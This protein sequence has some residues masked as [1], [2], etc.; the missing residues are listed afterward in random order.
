[1]SS[2]LPFTS[3]LVWTLWV[4]GAG[5]LS[6]SA[7][8]WIEG[9]YFQHQ[10]RQILKQPP[11][12]LPAAPPARDPAP[13]PPPTAFPAAADPEGLWGLLQ[14]PR[15]DLEVAVLGDVDSRSLRLGAGWIPG[16]SSPEGTGNTGIAGH[17]DTVFRKLSGIQPGDAMVLVR[18]GTAYRYSVAWT[19]V[20][21]PEDVDVLDATPEPALTLV[22]CYPF[23]YI[24]PA[25]RRFI[26]RGKRVPEKE[27]GS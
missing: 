5:L 17:R 7:Y 9:I 10:A 11:P 12:D 27:P 13:P 15:L 22:T 3:I 6:Y 23:R 8:S 19:R 16:T 21:N 2:R 24:G 4:A 18:E 26:V 25:P 20:V 14:I 1:M